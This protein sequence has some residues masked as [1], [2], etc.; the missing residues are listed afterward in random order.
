M[1][2]AGKVITGFSK[3]YVALYG[4]STSQGA[5]TVAYEDGTILAR[6]VSASLDVTSSDDNIFHAD[7]VDAESAGG[8]FGG[9]TLTLTV[10]GLKQAAERLILG[11]PEADTNGFVHYGDAMSIPYVGIGFI[12]RYMSDGATTYTPVVFRKAK[13]ATPGLEAA[14]QEEDIDWQT[15]ELTATLFR[16]DTATH[17]WKWVGGDE[18]TEAAAEAKLRT[19]LN[20]AA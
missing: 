5:T 10:D 6:G 11:L 2:A 1:S 9:G 19:A 8:I 15:Q 12:I 14:T 17:D 20:I 3:P 16:D 7:N 13:F 4:T 18:A